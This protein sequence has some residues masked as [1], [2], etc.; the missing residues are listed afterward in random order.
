[1]DAGHTVVVIEHHTSLIA[2]ADYVMEIGPEA[3]EAGGELIAS[4]TPEAIAKV[5][6]S[7]IAPY[8]KGLLKK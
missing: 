1:V 8:L 6:K 3:G 7:R 2:D 4:G 5:P